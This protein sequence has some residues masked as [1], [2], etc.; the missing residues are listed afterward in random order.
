MQGILYEESSA[1]LWLAVTVVLGGWTAWMTGRGI[2]QAWRPAWVAAAAALL[3]TMAVRFV[4][5]ALFEGSFLSVHYYLVD[6][7]VVLAIALLAHRATRTSQMVRQYRWLVER[8]GPL[9]WRE[10]PAGPAA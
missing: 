7:C 6:L 1:W 2:A 9:S 4:H 5:F 3:L 10:R 8:A